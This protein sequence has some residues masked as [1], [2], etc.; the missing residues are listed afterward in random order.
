M[1]KA[2]HIPYRDSKLTHYLKDSLG[3]ESKT[4]MIVQ[5]SPSSHDLSETVSTLQFSQRVSVIEKGAVKT[6]PSKRAITDN[7]RSKSAN[8]IEVEIP[9]AE[10][11]LTTSPYRSSRLPRRQ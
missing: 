10:T 7:K 3:G 5:V 1:N 9:T 2:S 11:S 4:M 6:N 8:R